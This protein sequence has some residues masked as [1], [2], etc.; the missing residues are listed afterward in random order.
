[1]SQGNKAKDM[2]RAVVE[3]A[4]ADGAIPVEEIPAVRKLLPKTT[5]I[6]KRTGPSAGATYVDD[7]FGVYEIRD[8]DDVQF[9]FAMQR[10]SVL[11]TCVDCGRKV[12]ISPDYECCNSC[13][14]ARERGWGG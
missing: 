3:K 8:G 5:A 4:I 2:I 10:K 9:Y 11:K 14:D 6:R 1:M 13:A 12:R 7:N